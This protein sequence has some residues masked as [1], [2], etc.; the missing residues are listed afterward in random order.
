MQ[1]HK[2]KSEVESRTINARRHHV[3]HKVCLPGCHS[4]A[5][6]RDGVLC[7]GSLGLTCTHLNA[8]S[9]SKLLPSL[10]GARGTFLSCSLRS[11][12]FQTGVLPFSLGKSSFDHC[13]LYPWISQPFQSSPHLAKWRLEMLTSKGMFRICGLVPEYVT[14]KI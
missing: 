7:P 1:R 8:V 3:E 11:S 14:L 9:V 13:R 5:W 2:A 10:L 6:H 12:S 4:L